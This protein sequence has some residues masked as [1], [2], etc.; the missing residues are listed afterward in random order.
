MKASNFINE[1]VEKTD[2]KDEPSGGLGVRQ[3][4]FSLLINHRKS[5][6][7]PR[8]NPENQVGRLCSSFTSNSCKAY[9][10]ISTT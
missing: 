1:Q 3:S 5:V 8:L 9:Q 7:I 10:G 6:L 4:L 2:E